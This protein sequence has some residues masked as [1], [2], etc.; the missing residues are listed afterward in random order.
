MAL[1][2]DAFDRIL[3]MVCLATASP[4]DCLNN[5]SAVAL[6]NCRETAL[7]PNC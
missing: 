1:H 2:W 5:I 6:P 7:H 4:G 3:C